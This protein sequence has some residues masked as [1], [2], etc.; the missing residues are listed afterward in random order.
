MLWCRDRLSVNVQK[1]QE[2]RL[3]GKEELRNVKYAVYS[4][5]L[6]SNVQ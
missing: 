1:R 2:D 6:P 4:I 3:K 5:C